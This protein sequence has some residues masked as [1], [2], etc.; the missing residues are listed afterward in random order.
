MLLG[1]SLYI[2]LV[3]MVYHAFIGDPISEM[4]SSAWVVFAYLI[5]FIPFI[6]RLKLFFLFPRFMLEN[7]NEEERDSEA[8][9]VITLTLAGFSFSALF[10][11]LVT[12]PAFSESG[13]DIQVSIYY[14]VIS[15]F[16]FVA[17][18]SIEAYKHTRWQQHISLTL[19]DIGR[20]SILC[21]F[22]AL[23]FVSPID[24]FLV[25]GVSFIFALGWL[26]DCNHRISLW[27]EFLTAQQRYLKNGCR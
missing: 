4:E 15:V 20:L 24:R 10:A 1:F 25:Y 14:V 5:P 11:L 18:F 8:G 21:C 13:A 9:R 19:E 27:S 17:S 23:M 6:L 2:F 16:S 12:L 22:V 7:L 3:F 26:V